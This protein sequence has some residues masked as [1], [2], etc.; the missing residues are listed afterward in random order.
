MAPRIDLNNINEIID[1]APTLN[2]TRKIFYKTMIAKRK[3]FIVDRAVEKIRAGEFDTTALARI[4][5]TSFEDSGEAL[6]EY[7]RALGE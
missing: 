6:R 1:N 5:E 7:E 4:G 2:D 3:E